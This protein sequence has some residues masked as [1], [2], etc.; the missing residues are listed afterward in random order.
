M[1]PVLGG[2]RAERRDVGPGISEDLRRF[3]EQHLQ[4]FDHPLERR[5]AATVESQG[6]T[7]TAIVGVSAITAARILGEVG[8]V[9]R[10]PTPAAFAS[11]NGTA[12]VPASSG[13]TQRHRL[14]R[15]GNRRLNRALYVIALTQT[16]HEPRA[17][18]Y[19]ARKRAE[20]K[21]RRE[22]MR[23]LKRRLS[24]VV[25]RQLVADARAT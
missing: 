11:A 12:P 6:T 23:C 8:D 15:G 5:L 18:A 1:A 21:T 2:E 7:L 20:G 25:Y 9:R 22:A 24:D 16:R 13:R 10:F 19:L 17:V 4:V 3:R 14:N